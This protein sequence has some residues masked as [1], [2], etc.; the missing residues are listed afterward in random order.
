MYF[1][2]GGVASAFTSVGGVVSISS[3]RPPTALV[4]SRAAAREDRFDISMF[5]FSFEFFVAVSS[6]GGENIKF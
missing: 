1:R 2:S 5:V 4:G 6:S 3:K